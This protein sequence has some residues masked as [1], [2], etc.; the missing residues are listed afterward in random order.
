[1]RN[2]LSLRS[3]PVRTAFF[4]ACSATAALAY[5]LSGKVIDRSSRIPVAGAQV[6]ILRSG[7]PAV[8]ADLVTA[9]NGTFQVP[10]ISAGDYRMEVARTNFLDALA[11]LQVAGDREVTFVVSLI[12]YGVISGRVLDQNGNPVRD[13]RVIPMIEDEAG[14]R[15]LGAMG[16]HEATT[17]DRG[18]FRF[19]RLVPGQYLLGLSFASASSSIG[20]NFLLLM[21]NSRPRVFRITGGEEFADASFTLAPSS[22]SRIRGTVQT[23]KSGSVFGVVLVARDRPAVS[24]A[25]T[26]TQPDGTFQFEGIPAGNYELIAAGPVQAYGGAAVV[27]REGALFGRASL[28]LA[29]QNI[30]GVLLPVSEGRSVALVLSSRAEEHC[31]ATARVRLYPLSDSG[32]IAPGPVDL[33]VNVVHRI[34]GLAPGR[35]GAEIAGNDIPCYPEAPV[36]FDV[37]EANTSEPVVLAIRKAGSIEGRLID[38]ANPVGYE[39]ALVPSFRDTEEAGPIRLAYPNPGGTFTFIGL[40]P[41]SYRLEV[42]PANGDAGSVMSVNVPAGAS[43][44]VRVAAPRVR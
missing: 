39:I 18:Q 31:P 12:H 8:V 24:I 25:H 9:K 40:R 7:S 15:R 38:A 14:L 10:D 16:E 35:Y 22:T 13:A 32:V 2:C 4:L 6:R 28:Q 43:T 11:Q 34:D 19:F 42:N 26:R 29:G 30:E 21:E 3:A 36:S 20:S 5:P 17:D 37:T 23:E 44:P 1:M 27:V 41:G 33:A